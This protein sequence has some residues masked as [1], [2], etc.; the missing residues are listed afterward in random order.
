M[1]RTP[2]PTR[3]KILN[4]EPNKNRINRNEPQPSERMPACPIWLSIAAKRIWR[5]EAPALHKARLLTFVD[6]PAFANYCLLRAMLKQAYEELDGS[7][8]HEYTNKN[9]STN[10]ITKPQVTIIHTCTAQL[11]SLSAKFGMTP[12]D[13]SKITLD[14]DSGNEDELDIFL[15]TGKMN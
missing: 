6:G 1:A 12:A 8:T 10:E 2:R 4:G 7:L 15:K 5:H 13:R 9:G 3:I 11:I 14:K